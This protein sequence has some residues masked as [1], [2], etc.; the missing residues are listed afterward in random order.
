M[1]YLIKD[2]Y[3][4]VQMIVQ[5]SCPAQDPKVINA[6]VAEYTNSENNTVDTEA[7]MD[8]FT[9]NGFNVFGYKMV[10]FSVLFDK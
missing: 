9:K 4:T 7:L 8:A 5:G 1:L 2:F 10:G 6:L 3:G